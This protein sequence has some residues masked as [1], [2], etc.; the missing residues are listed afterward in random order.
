MAH[1][2]IFIV[3]FLLPVAEIGTIASHATNDFDLLSTLDKRLS[4]RLVCACQR[5]EVEQ[6]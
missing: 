4:R 5:T 6:R 2:F 3:F 1:I